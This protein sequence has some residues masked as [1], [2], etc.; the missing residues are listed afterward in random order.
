M[1]GKSVIQ[2]MLAAYDQSLG[3]PLEVDIQAAQIH[4]REVNQVRTFK[5]VWYK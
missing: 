5:Y 1:L 3:V 2:Q 4:W